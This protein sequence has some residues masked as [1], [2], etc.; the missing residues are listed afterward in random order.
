[1]SRSIEAFL[2]KRKVTVQGACLEVGGIVQGDCLE[3]L[4][5]YPDNHFDAVVTDP[6]YGLS[7]EPDAAEVLSKWL[8]GEDYNHRGG[9][10]MGKKW[11]SFVPGPSVWR[12]VL[13]V[14]KP[15]GHALVFAGTRTYDL[16][17][18]SM[19][20]AG[21]QIRDQLAWIYG[22]GFPK[23]LNVAAAIDKAAGKLEHRGKA[24]VTAGQIEGKPYLPSPDTKVKAYVSV[25]T[26]GAAWNGWGTALKPAQEPIVL[27]RKPL[28]GTV[29]SNVLQYGTGGINVDAGRVGAGRWPANVLFDGAAAEMLDGQSDDSGGASRFF[30]VTKASRKEREAGL[31]GFRKASAGELTSR[32]EGSKGLNSPRAGAGRT[33]KNGRV[34][35][36]PTVKPIALMRYLVRLITPP[37]GLVLDPYV[38]S[39][40]TGIA[41]KIEGFGFVGIELS[42][43][44]VRIANARIAHVEG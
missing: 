5:R 3:V 39:G 17:V 13:R 34:N 28:A 4:Q 44:Y 23:S 21:F 37:G 18:M 16:M 25:D 6:P 27:A 24:F 10:F 38:G 2:K 36:H 32:K 12:E 29:A 15:G 9:G 31:E 43:E 22:S 40:T 7:K 11:D 20:I 30:Y 33:S 14:L 19:R 42:E 35:T 8:A 1:M 26:P 41:A